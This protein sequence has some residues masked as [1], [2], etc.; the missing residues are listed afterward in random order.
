[1]GTKKSTQKAER[2][3]AAKAAGK[4]GS[5]AVALGE[6]DATRQNAGDEFARLQRRLLVAVAQLDLA[7]QSFGDLSGLSSDHSK[8][9]LVVYETA[10]ELDA[11]YDALD[12]WHTHARKETQP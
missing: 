8:A 11:I 3:N 12:K 7:R 9:G 2:L 1:M 6:P 10:K 5:Y 4:E